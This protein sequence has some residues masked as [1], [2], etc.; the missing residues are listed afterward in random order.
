MHGISLLKKWLERNGSIK[1]LAR[2]DATL[3]VVDA[4]LNGAKLALTHLGRHRVGGAFV[5]HH[6]KPSIACSVIDI[7]IERGST[8][9]RRSPET[10]FP[11]CAAR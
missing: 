1:H 10:C 9:T 2:V 8:S 7:C 3:R 6:I 11:G 5:K 4:L